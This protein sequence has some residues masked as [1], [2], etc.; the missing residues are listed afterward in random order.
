MVNRPGKVF[1]GQARMANV[2]KRMEI[3]AEVELRR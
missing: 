3:D 2:R 1:L